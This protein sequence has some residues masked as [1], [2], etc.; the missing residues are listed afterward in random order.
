[1]LKLLVRFRYLLIACLLWLTI[2]SLLYTLNPSPGPISGLVK[3][4]PAQ[5]HQHLLTAVGS[6]QQQQYRGNNGEANNSNDAKDWPLKHNNAQLSS[7]SYSSSSVISSTNQSRW[8]SPSDASGAGSDVWAHFDAASYLAASTV[9]PNG[10]AYSRNKFNQRA[11][12]QLPPDRPI[13]DTRH[14]LCRRKHYEVEKLSPT[15]VIITFHN[16]ARSTL[17]RT[18]ASVLNRSP[19]SLIT[20]II[21][22]DDFS[23]DPADGR[24]LEA[25]GKVRV[26]RNAKREGLVRSRI[27]GADAARGPVLTFLDSHCECNVQWLEPLLERVRE[28]PL[29]VVSP[30]ID[31]IGLDDFRYIAASAELRGGFD[32][33]L[34]FKWEVLPSQLHSERMANDMVAPIKTPMIAGGLFSVNKTTFDYYGKYDAQMDIWGGENLEISFRMWQCAA[35]LEIIPCSRVGHVFRK[36]HP[37]DFPGG[38][39]SV[40][41]RNTRRAAE[42]WMDEYKVLYY[43]AYPPA[44]YVPFGDIGERMALRRRLGCRPFSWYMANV[45]PELKPVTMG[46][47]GGL[48]SPMAA[49]NNGL[50][51]MVLSKHGAIRQAVQDQPPGLCLDTM[52]SQDGSGQQK[53]AP[54]HLSLYQC[55]G[56]GANQDWEVTSTG[57]FRHGKL[58]ITVS[59]FEPGRPVV[60]AEC[61][62]D[63]AQKWV[64][65]FDRHI[66]LLSRNL[67]LDAR[68]IRQTGIVADVCNAGSAS[69]QWRFDLVA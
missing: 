31:V 40:F 42:V 47:G 17:L 38:S 64:W 6:Q 22:V 52:G 20:E 67:C 66:K 2:F 53:E 11:S 59:G 12:D 69:Q 36:Q 25:I 55:H 30:V 8:W 63:D 23:D 10:D 5:A 65:A 1:M 29:L 44:K 32:W 35:G 27:V 49:D 50:G 13:M 41:A 62:A 57:L 58:C 43:D 45:Y 15:S 7:S 14:L 18:V 51:D 4:A 34:V 24:L 26:L 19:P 46:Y 28:N 37:Y 3:Q 68:F 21:L 56:Q 9:A 60:L 39:G 33:N 61:V 54:G 16:E 48:P